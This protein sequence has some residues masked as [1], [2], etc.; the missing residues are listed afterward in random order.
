[1]ALIK[2]RYPD[3]YPYPA[4]YNWCKENCKGAFYSGSDWQNWVVG[5]NN[6]M[7]QFR[8]ESDAV[9]FAIKWS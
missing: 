7:V 3:K 1:M 5:E 4:V 8:L 6:R 9:M 2:V